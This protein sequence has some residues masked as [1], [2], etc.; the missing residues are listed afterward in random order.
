MLQHSL[1][2]PVTQSSVTALITPTIT[3][4]PARGLCTD[5]G[6]SRSSNPK[7]CG[8]ACEFIKP[9][10]ARLEAAVHGRVRDVAKPDELFFGPHK[11][12]TAPAQGRREAVTRPQPG[13][14]TIGVNAPSIDNSAPVM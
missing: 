2:F 5:S 4:G 8:Q 9:D 12:M 13:Y 6:L 7:R 14:T 10:Y 1:A 3:G 11:R